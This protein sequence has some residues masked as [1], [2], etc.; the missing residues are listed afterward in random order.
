MYTITCHIFMTISFH[1][2][3]LLSVGKM[4]NNFI[5]LLVYQVKY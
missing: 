5:N 4:F 2:I 1:L 3:N